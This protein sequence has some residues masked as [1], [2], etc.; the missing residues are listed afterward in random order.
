MLAKVRTAQRGISL[1]EATIILG[2][3]SVLAAVMAPTIRGYVVNAQQVGAKHDVEEIGA[4]LSRMLTD[5]GDTWVLRDGNGAAAT[6]EPVHTSGNRVDLLVSAG[7][8]PAVQTA[9]SVGG[10]PDWSTA[11]NNTTVQLLDEFLV[12][13][14]PSDSAA[15]AYRSATNMS[16]ATSYDPADGATFNSPKAWRGAYLPGPISA[17]PWGNRY[18]VNVEYLGRALGAGPSGNVND[19]IVLSAGNNGVVEIRYDTDGATSGN[20]IYHVVTGGTR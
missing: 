5:V 13:N 14:T 1:I 4:A 17:D 6:N 11:I 16:V 2:V 19:V 15:N 8:T 20:D 9:R 3:V 18:M 10:P 7:R 12:E